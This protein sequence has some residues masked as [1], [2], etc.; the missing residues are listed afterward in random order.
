MKRWRR[1]AL[2]TASAYFIIGVSLAPVLPGSTILWNTLMILGGVF[3]LGMVLFKIVVFG[4]IAATC[5]IAA[6]VLRCLAFSLNIWPPTLLTDQEL[7]AAAVIW[8]L[9]A[10]EVGSVWCRVIIP[11]IKL[12]KAMEELDGR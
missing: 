9:L 8:F 2:I 3:G 12:D 11:G 6:S 7:M 10:Y 4:Q 5:M 1:E